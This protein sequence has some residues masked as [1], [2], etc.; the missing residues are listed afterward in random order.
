MPTNQRNR[1]SYSSRSTK[2]RSERIEWNACKGIARSNFSGAID[3]RPIGEYSAAKSR[4]S[5]DSASFTIAR[6]VR[7]D[8]HAAL[9]PRDPRS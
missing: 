2:S 7:S 6:I 3:G 4:S 1:R 5:A 8:D 9:A